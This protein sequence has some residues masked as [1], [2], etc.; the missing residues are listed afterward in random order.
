MDGERAVVLIAGSA[1]SEPAH[2]HETVAPAA[3]L[4]LGGGGVGGGGTGRDYCGIDLTACLRGMD[5]AAGDDDSDQAD[6]LRRLCRW[7]APTTVRLG[8]GG[9]DGE[10]VDT[11]LAALVRVG[12]PREGG[13]PSAE[14]AEL[15]RDNK[16]IA[17]TWTLQSQPTDSLPP[18]LNSG[19][20]SA[21][22]KFP[23]PGGTGTPLM[24][25]VFASK[26]A[27]IE[28]GVLPPPL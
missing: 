17:L 2:V 3:G 10:D 18:P 23:T 22:F 9:G 8:G 5:C 12:Y 24:V 15:L 13:A 1:L 16:P 26:Q 27:A 20:G 7:R 25:T 28:A 4:T 6:K 19:L 14:D 21:T 11:E